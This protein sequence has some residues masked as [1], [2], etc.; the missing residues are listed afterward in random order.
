MFSEEE[1]DE[2]EEEEEEEEE[3]EPEDDSHL[4]VR[5]GAQ[6]SK[7]LPAKLNSIFLF[8]FS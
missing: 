3:D 8:P 5:L 2:E 6:N 4:Q 1:E 7:S